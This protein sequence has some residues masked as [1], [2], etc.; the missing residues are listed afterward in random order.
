MRRLFTSIVIVSPSRTAAIGP[1]RAASGAMWAPI[2]P[3]VAPEKR[4]SVSRATESPNPSPAGGPLVAD[5]HHVARP[6]LARGYGGHGG[7]FVVEHAC[8][9]AVMDALV[10]GEL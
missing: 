4:P 7:L 2:K 1:P 3:C 8:G 9:A 10:A 5:H 6:Q